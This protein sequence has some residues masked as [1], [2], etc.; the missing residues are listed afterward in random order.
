MPQ[1]T[2]LLETKPNDNMNNLNNIPDEALM[3]IITETGVDWNFFALKVMISRLRLKLSMS[4]D[5]E[6]TQQCCNELREL[7]YKSRNIPNA[8][9]DLHIIRERFVIDE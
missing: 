2:L 9:I 7:L 8:I 5:E 1:F 4:N 3:R 6:T